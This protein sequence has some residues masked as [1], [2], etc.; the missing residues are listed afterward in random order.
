MPVCTINHPGLQG[1]IRFAWIS[2]IITSK[3]GKQQSAWPHPFTFCNQL[4]YADIKLGDGWTN[5]QSCCLSLWSWIHQ[6]RKPFLPCLI[7]LLTLVIWWVKLVFLIV[8]CL[9]AKIRLVDIIHY[10]LMT[11][12]LSLSSSLS[13]ALP[14]SCV[15]LPMYGWSNQVSGQDLWF[16]EF[17]KMLLVAVW[18]ALQVVQNQCL[19]SIG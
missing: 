7:L 5:S 14:V 8:L 4:M 19:A 10:S 1:E 13:L 18:L 15:M 6:I 2:F 16:L 12:N 3:I 11:S 9:R 17:G